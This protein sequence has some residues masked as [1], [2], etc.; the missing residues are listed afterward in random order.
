MNTPVAD[1]Q[2]FALEQAAGDRQELGVDD[3]IAFIHGHF[4]PAKYHLLEGQ[5]RATDADMDAPPG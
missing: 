1:R 2:R 4:L 3:N 5:R